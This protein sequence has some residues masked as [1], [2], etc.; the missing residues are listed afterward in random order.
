MQQIIKKL[1]NGGLDSDSAEFLVPKECFI[2]GQN[3]RIGGTTDLG[4]V[5]YIESI[6]ENAEKFHVLNS[7]G[8]NITI[9]F[10]SDAEEGWI[11]KF[12]WSSTGNHGIF[13]FDI[14]NETWYDL[15]LE[16][17]V[18]GGL[19]FEK[20]QLIH[21]ARIE[22]G[23]V[24]WCNAEQNQPRR[25]NIRAAAN[26]YAPGTF[27]DV[28]A[29]TTPISQDVIYWIRRQPGLPPIMTKMIASPVINNFIKDEGF[30]A[31]FRYIYRDYEIST[32]SE[33]SELANYNAPDDE[34][35]ALNIEIPVGEYIEQ[36]VLQVDLVI[37]YASTGKSFVIRSW[38]KNV[39]L[40][41]AAIN[42]HNSGAELLYF[43][44][45]NDFIGTALDDAYSVKPYDSLPI[46]AQT[47]E[48]A[49]NRSFMLNYTLGYDT[50]VAPTSLDAVFVTQTEGETVTGTWW[51]MQWRP[52]PFGSPDTYYVLYLENIGAYSGYYGYLPFPGPVGTVSTPPILP[53]IADYP[54][55]LALAGY[56]AN[57]ILLYFSL[58]LSGYVNFIP[59]SSTAS[60]T[61]SPETVT[62]VGANVFK[63]DA[64]YQIALQ[65]RD[66]AGRKCG[67]ITNSG[68]IFTT[69]DRA[70]DTI[71]FTTALTWTLSNSNKLAEIP[72]WAFYY[73]ILISKCLRTRFFLEARAKNITYVVKD[74]DGEYE[75]N[76]NAYADDLNG[77]AIDITLLNGYGMGYVWAEGD[78]IK[79]Y[80]DGDAT[81]YTLSL[82]GQEG[83]WVIAELKDLGTIGNTASPYLT[84]LFEIYTP[85]RRSSNEP[86]Y[87]VAQ[88][89]KI[90]DP[91]T[92]DRE[93]SVL[94]GSIGGDVTL[95]SR[96][97]GSASYFTE[98]MSPNDKYPYQ[99]NTDSGRPNF[100]DTIGQETKTNDIAYSDRLIAGTRTNGLSTFEALNTKDVPIECGDGMK[101]QVADKITE[102]GNIMLAICANETVSLYLSEAQLLGSTGN[103]FLAQA[104][105]V[106][107]TVNVLKGSYG[108]LN[109]E[110]VV[111]SSGRV[112]FYSL[113]RGCFVS[114]S[115]NGLFPI[116]DYGLKRVS[117]LFSQ[118][119][120]GLSQE[121]IE[122]MGSRPF[123]FG[124][125]DPYHNE[126]YWSIP[127]TTLTPPKG[128]L[129]DYVSPEPLVIYPYDIYDG[130]GKVLVFKMNEDRWATPHSYETEYFVDIRDFLYSAKD[131]SLFKHNNDNGTDDT[132]SRWYGS[133][134]NPAIG[135]I[136]NEEPNI[137]KQYLTLSV[138]GNGF[139][140]SW[141]HHR[142][143]LPN[144]QSTDCEEWENRS[145][146]LY[147]A[148]GILRDRLSPNVSGT[149][150]E[151][152]FTGDKMLGQ[153][154]KVYVEFETRE[155]IQIRFFNVGAVVYNG[156]KT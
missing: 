132:Y 71:A 66:F 27:D 49:R 7:G 65:F 98:N 112:F 119:Y 22:N 100:I 92:D 31:S 6:L 154:M 107:G 101:L 47:I 103:A 12:N 16:A 58:D 54:T 50:P 70:Y 28:D 95:L 156:Q 79:I 136:I 35:N 123:V 104:S 109:P 87:G 99:W 73:D 62:L 150:D 81:V 118:A 8:E 85:F 48:I 151:K 130:L 142:T 110:S 135:F 152:L 145:G 93:Y 76:T 60:I 97:D 146:V 78:V 15:L 155:L 21:S 4:G 75:F 126:V 77:V 94:T 144:V 89:Y 133:Q 140:P 40:D 57:D 18:T 26:L 121:E 84:G 52:S 86:Y 129:E 24:Y 2:S 80:K 83:N 11:V 3:V 17:D 148:N 90:T 115:N 46:Y 44:Y 69:P 36:D 1:L 53:I 82:L 113:I 96:G 9:G 131:G 74:I 117:H 125:V 88:S 19:N 106:I 147:E 34:F 153:W 13:L 111:L 23:N 122:E 63:S 128:Y 137:E 51:E 120:A 138:E 116:S 61:N 139:E 39:A 134:V 56:T 108:T 105:D 33:L 141:V 29:Y 38:N 55:E 102:Q 68:M 43:D 127:T 67:A 42:N 72:D 149:F 37:K 114:Y 25:F 124:G 14:I 59:T 64:P 5:G 45:Y 30:W 10:A 32:L 41:L 91:A 20:N 143:E